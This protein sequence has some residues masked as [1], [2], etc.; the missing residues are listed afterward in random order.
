MMS[1]IEQE[2]KDCWSCA[3]QNILLQTTL[4]GICTW[5]EKNNKG[6]NKEIPADLVDKGCK[7]WI[8]KTDR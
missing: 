5:F 1:I 7:Q 3:Y 4:L 6:Q 8:R 2:K